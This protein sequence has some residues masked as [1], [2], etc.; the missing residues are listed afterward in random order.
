VLNAC[1]G[2][3]YYVVVVEM[4]VNNEI[5]LDTLAKPHCF[6]LISENQA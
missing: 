2:C 5:G 4:V 3:V 1:G 6:G